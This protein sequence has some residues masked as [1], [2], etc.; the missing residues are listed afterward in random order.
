MSLLESFFDL[1]RLVAILFLPVTWTV[2]TLSYA[3]RGAGVTRLRIAL[4]TG[5]VLHDYHSSTSV[6]LFKFA[7]IPQ[8]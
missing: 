2:Y 5:V 4:L 3:G 1:A 7:S 8:P 6:L